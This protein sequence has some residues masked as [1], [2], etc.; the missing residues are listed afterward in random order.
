MWS[1]NR[2]HTLTRTRPPPLLVQVGVFCSWFMFDNFMGI[3]L[4]KDG[5]S[6]VTFQQL[7]NWQTCSAWDG[8][9]ASG[10]STANGGFVSFDNPCDYFT[11]R[12]IRR[13]SA[14]PGQW[15]CCSCLC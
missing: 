2:M 8:F 11:V 7:T 10:Y 3:D 1:R 6:V 5:H 12:P 14:R 13:R 9:Q 15:W 4:S